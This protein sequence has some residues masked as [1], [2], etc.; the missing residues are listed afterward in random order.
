MMLV[1][2]AA[3]AVGVDGAGGVAAVDV[4]GTVVGVFLPPS[5][6]AVVVTIVVVSPPTVTLR[7]TMARDAV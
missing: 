3:A 1:V 6:L 4:D 7:Q 2:A 5:T